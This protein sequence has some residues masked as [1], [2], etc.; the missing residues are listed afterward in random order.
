MLPHL[1]DAPVD[2]DL[3]HER[4]A[5]RVETAGRVGL[6]VVVGL[7]LALAGVFGGAG[8][9]VRAEARVGDFGVRYDRTARL[10]A[11]TT[12]AVSLPP[13]DSVAVLGPS[14]ADRLRIDVV[15]PAPT[16]E[17]GTPGGGLRLMTTP[18]GTL[19][20]HARPRR[21]G[22]LTGTVSLPDGRAVRVR[23]FVYP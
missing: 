12:I 23:L 3:P 2:E 5:R 14:L 1:P 9:L 15:R 18:G 17:A 4:R 6:G 21:P 19:V 22:R 20:L 7:A 10:D 16:A 13:G 11:P 8:P